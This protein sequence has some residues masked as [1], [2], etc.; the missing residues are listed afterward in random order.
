MKSETGMPAAMGHS[1]FVIRHFTFP[2]LVAALAFCLLPSPL[3]LAASPLGTAFTFQ[4]KLTDGGPSANGRYDFEFTLYDAATGGNHV[5]GPL[6][7]N[8]VGVTNGL[9]TV[10]LDFGVGMFTGE[11]RWLEIA[12]SS[13][14][15]GR[16][17]TFPARLSLTPAPYALHALGFSGT[18]AAS[19]LTGTISSN[20]IGAGSITTLMLAPGAVGSNQLASGAVTATKVAA[21]SNWFALTI[22]NPTPADV[23]YF[24]SAVAALGTD[25][26]L[27]GAYHDHTSATAPGAAYLFSAQGTLLTTFTNPTPPS[28]Q[29]FGMSV[30]ALGTDGVLIGAYGYGPAEA[31][32]AGAVYL[33]RTNG[34]LLTTFTHPSP[35]YDDCFGSS[36]VAVG[37]DRVLIGSRGYSAGASGAG[38]AYLFGTN[39]TLLATFTNPTPAVNDFFGVSA[40]AVGTDRLLIGAPNDNTGGT[41]AGAAYLFS[42]NG[43]LLTTFTNV[44]PA[45]GDRFGGSV[46]AVGTDRVLIG[47]AGAGA[48]YLFGT[49]GTLLTT[50]TNPTPAVDAW[51][52]CS[53]AAVG[54]DRVLIGAYGDSTGAS[55]AGAAYLFSTNG[56]LLTAFTNPTPAA[57]D[58][59]GSGVAAVGTDQVLIGAPFDSTGAPD[60]GAAYLFSTQTYTPGLV[61]D[62]VNARSITTR[63]LED[64]AVT[65]AKLDSSIGVW[66]RSWEDVFRLDGDVGVGTSTPAARLH[67]A[68][69]AFVGG[70]D[71]TATGHT[72]RLILGD[73]NHVVRSV[74]GSGLRFGV[75]PDADALTVQDDTGN[76]GVGTTN[77]LA[78]LHVASAGAQPQLEL[79]QTA[80]VDFARLRFRPA[81]TND[82][83][84]IAAGWGNVMNFWNG[85]Q[86][87]VM[88]LDS[89]GNLTINGT[90][91]PSSDR[92][93]KEDVR[94]VNAKDILEK[95]AVLPVTGWQFKANPAARHVGPMAQDFHAA[96]G[97]GVDD[98]HI[99]TVDAD[100][101]ALAA[102]QGLN[103][104]LEAAV[105][106]KD[107]RIADLERRL[108]A[109]EQLVKTMTR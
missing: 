36:V 81:G 20:H 24:G 19:Q 74:Y 42:T 55:E 97:L 47:A 76:V 30:A 4:G 98:K 45:A 29:Q 46:A 67:V 17:A 11:A 9:F 108:A 65:P 7:V 102:I 103:Q 10:P 61:A 53:V 18:V 21:V 107:A 1:S 26:V 5:A 70:T 79:Q 99:A 92:N 44:T 32:Q 104:K 31:W 71:F 15:V 93:A 90:Y 105:K 51:F 6:P 25:R 8:S 38:A 40:A 88:K 109:L 60:A 78:R 94:P 59:F 85:R 41:M 39:G 106:E 56:I 83:W 87:N 86:G 22:A 77:P 82:T 13:S 84:D 89:A 91:S 62:G 80:A 64:G 35:T 57:S 49:N 23:D 3:C 43:T 66:T 100:G 101:V 69:D 72:A 58:R 16:F 73:V 96:F 12:V 28:R 33:F 52:G 14:G 68:G 34:A 54:T 75:W 48:A 95:V 50:F 2:L 27:I 63:S 37:A